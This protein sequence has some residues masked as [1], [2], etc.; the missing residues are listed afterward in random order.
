MFALALVVAACGDDDSATT[1]AAPGTTAPPTTAAGTTAAPT[2]AA[3]TTAAPTTAPPTTADPAAARVA[4][5]AAFAGDYT[6][7]WQNTTFG[8]TGASNFKVAVDEVAQFALVTIDLDGNVFGG[9]DPDPFLIEIDLTQEPPYTFTTDLMGEATLDVD[10]A[11]NVTLEAPAVPGLGGL[12]LTVEGSVLGDI[13][14]TIGDG[15]GGVFAEGVLV[16]E[17]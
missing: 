6:G 1:T 12:P 8:S 9:A 10:A 17:Q 7:E 3:P 14:Y 5:A 15:A 11:G 2:T 16:V 13:T 4:A